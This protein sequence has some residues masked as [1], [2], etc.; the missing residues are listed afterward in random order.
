MGTVGLITA[1]ASFAFSG[2][3]TDRDEAVRAGD[4]ATLA[5]GVLTRLADGTGGE[6]GGSVTGSTRQTLT[7]SISGG[8]SSGGAGLT[9]ASLGG[10][11]T[12][13]ARVTGLSVGVGL[14]AAVA[15]DTLCGSVTISDSS[16]GAVQTVTSIGVGTG[17]ADL[18]AGLGRIGDLD[19][20]TLSARDAL[21][22]TVAGSDGVLRATLAESAISGE[23]TGQT[24]IAVSVVEVGFETATA[25]HA[26]CRSR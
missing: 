23:E 16:I 12:R 22:R 20:V 21:A 18:A 13:S 4:A 15:R 8:D 9:T 2:T 19:S 5:A 24:R 17:R 25:R 3:S 7:S 11:L 1:R 26:L 14:V 10:E 6:R